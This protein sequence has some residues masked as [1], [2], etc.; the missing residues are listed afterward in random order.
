[1]KFSIESIALKAALTRLG[2]VVQNNSKIPVLHCVHIE[3]TDNKIELRACDCDQFVS[4]IFEADV[5]TNGFTVLPFKQFKSAC[6]TAYA[7]R[8]K[9]TVQVDDKTANL[10][11]DGDMPFSWS[12]A[13]QDFEDYP[14][15]PDVETG[16]ASFSV[17]DIQKLLGNV[18]FAM[19]N[20]PTRYYLN[21]AYLH[22][23][24]SDLIAV[25]TDGHKLA[26]QRIQFPPETDTNQFTTSG[27]NT[28]GIIPKKAVSFILKN[29]PKNGSNEPVMLSWNQHYLKFEAP[30]FVLYTKLVD[31]TFPDYTR[32]IPKEDFTTKVQLDR[33]VILRAI[34]AFLKYG[35][36]KEA[37][38]IRI[39][40]TS[41]DLKKR[42]V[43]HGEIFCRI[44]GVTQGKDI[45]ICFNTS[46][47]AQILKA[48]HSDKIS[49]SIESDHSP[50]RL[51]NH[52]DDSYLCVVMPMRSKGVW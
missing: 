44:A 28:S 16:R 2:N 22:L 12:F 10:T 17:T 24:N 3:A 1:M 47:L 5:K 31:G 7:D 42:C 45:E 35:D 39:N 30:N 41:L 27:Q 18:A 32:I 52:N 11:M 46:Y 20:E 4:V 36:K 21:G 51:T 43:E 19:S 40:P 26:I 29:L 25:A 49:L 8:A 14:S 38:D 33:S 34:S 9:L 48:L 15:F 13:V 6:E 37:T 50:A 23:E